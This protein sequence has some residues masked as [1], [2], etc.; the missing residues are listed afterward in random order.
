MTYGAGIRSA[1]H[2][3]KPLLAHIHATEIDRTNGHPNAWIFEKER[4]GLLR[5]DGIIAVSNFTKNILKN[6]YGIPAEKI[7]VVHNAHENIA[8]SLISQKESWKTPKNH[9]VLFLGR[10]TIQKNPHQFLKVA[11]RVRDHR[12]DVQ[13]V[14]AGTGPMFAELIE[15]TCVLGLSDCMAF[16]GNVTKE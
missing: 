10:L 12:K 16:A 9:L 6:E 14:I 13:F 7:T 2:H 11:R 1:S 15:R 8:S 3:Q 4:E 5:A